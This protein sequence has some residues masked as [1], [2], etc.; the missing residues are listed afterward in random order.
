MAVMLI[1]HGEW[2]VR[3]AP[4]YAQVPRGATMHFYSE[5]LK[6]LGETAA[7]EVRTLSE[8][9][10]EAE[11]NQ[12]AGEYMTV[13]NYTLIKLEPDLL[14]HCKTLTADSVTPLFVGQDGWPDEVQLCTD[15][16]GTLCGGGRHNCDGLF[17][18]DWLENE[19]CYWMACRVVDLRGARTAGG[20]GAKEP[21]SGWYD[22]GEALG[23]NAA[24][25]VLGYVEPDHQRFIDEFT[26]LSGPER[27]DRW[28]NQ[29]S[30]DEKRALMFSRELKLWV[31]E[32]GLHAEGS[33]IGDLI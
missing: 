6:A 20:P 25:D 28:N 26:A 3:G 7:I 17:S 24:Q 32:E 33:A 29:L 1:G 18:A 19:E 22:G 16:D 30:D 10:A 8:L 23:V 11:P 9:F 31:V 21:A 4:A 27:L 14:A 13:P 15:A 5:N 12:T 2:N